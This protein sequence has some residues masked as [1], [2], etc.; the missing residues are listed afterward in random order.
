FEASEVRTMMDEAK[1]TDEWRGIILFG[2]HTG[3]RLGD[4]R[5]LGREHIDGTDLVIRPGK[6][7]RTKKVIRIP[8]TPPLLAWTGER[9]GKFFPKALETSIPTLSMQFTAIMKR[10]G[11]PAKVTLPG[12]IVVKRSF[13]S[14]R[15][16]F[17]SWLAEADIH[18]DVRKKLTGHASDA[19][20][21][22]Y[23]HHDEALARA[24]ATLPDFSR[25]ESA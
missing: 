22:K 10:A 25:T 24:V 20:H 7:S 6:T 4:I 16:S 5:Q 1:T 23:T 12:G 15:H 18:A 19:Q 17:T 8:L 2:G 3:L 13:H 14:L 21:A 9:R 11:V